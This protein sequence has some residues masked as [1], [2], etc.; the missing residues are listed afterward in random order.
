[1]EQTLKNWDYDDSV[2]KMKPKIYKLKNLTLEIYRELW[3]ARKALSSQ[4]ART[5][6]VTNVTKSWGDYCDE[7]GIS[8]MTAHRW[9]E[10]YDHKKRKL[11][12]AP[13]KNK[14]KVEE[15]V[16]EI[17]KLEEQLVVEIWDAVIET[18]YTIY[19]IVPGL[20]KKDDLRKRLE[21]EEV[22]LP[23]LVTIFLSAQIEYFQRF[24]EWLPTLT[25]NVVEKLSR[26]DE[27]KS[28]VKVLHIYSLHVYWYAY[29]FSGE[30]NFH[31]TMMEC[32][33]NLR[34]SEYMKWIKK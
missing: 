21:G 27:L 20:M 13:K 28:I 23:F 8:R 17:E 29:F 1:M 6:L 18:A 5:D 15:Y 4:G 30:Q 34:G 24:K 22:Y 3:I 11:I 26:K 7:I 10:R 12:E 19:T 14:S 9:L 16:S 32:K 25:L 2:K 31:T 33:E